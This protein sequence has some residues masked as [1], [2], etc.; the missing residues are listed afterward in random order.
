MNG[1]GGLFDVSDA[2]LLFTEVVKGAIP[3]GVAFALGQLVVNTF[4]RMAF[5]GKIEFH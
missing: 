1:K 4:M 2:I 5:G 3:Y